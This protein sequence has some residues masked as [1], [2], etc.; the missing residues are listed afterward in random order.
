MK[1]IFAFLVVFL[2]VHTAQ[3]QG[4][5]TF[6]KGL[7]EKPSTPSTWLDGCEVLITPHGDVR[8][9]CKITMTDLVGNI[10]NAKLVVVAEKS[11]RLALRRPVM[12]PDYLEADVEAR[13]AG[14]TV[15]KYHVVELFLNWGGGSTV[16]AQIWLTWMPDAVAKERGKKGTLIA[17]KVPSYVHA[18]NPTVSQYDRPYVE[19]M[20]SS[21]RA[22][23]DDTADIKSVLTEILG[24]GGLIIGSAGEHLSGKKA[25][26]KL[27][28]WKIKLA[29]AGEIAQSDSWAIRKIIGTTTNGV[30]LPYLGFFYSPYFQPSGEGPQGVKGLAVFMLLK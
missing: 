26:K 2:S 16:K 10:P 24:N 21:S 13:V 6:V 30:S 27:A 7:A 17:P 5:K 1:R 23:V 29:G 15:A 4:F 28:A 3:A 22:S 19:S 14:K 9:P 12:D 18:I 8:T 20:Y 11:S 25:V